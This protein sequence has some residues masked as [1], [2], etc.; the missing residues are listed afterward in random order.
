MR[1]RRERNRG[2]TTGYDHVTVTEEFSNECKRN[3]GDTAFLNIIW[4]VGLK[5]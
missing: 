2:P 5:D 3:E 1:C 4:A